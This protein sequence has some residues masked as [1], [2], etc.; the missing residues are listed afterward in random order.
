[1]DNELLNEIHM[2]KNHSDETRRIYKHAVDNYTKFCSMS[3][4][5]LLEEAESE[6]ENSKKSIKKINHLEKINSSSIMKKTHI[7]A[8]WVR[9]LKT[10]KVTKTTHE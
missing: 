6:E 9:Y 8:H 2:V 3:L 1:M 4:S 10:K 5:E 7:S